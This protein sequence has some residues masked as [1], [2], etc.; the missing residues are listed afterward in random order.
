MIAWHRW[1]P[2][3]LCVRACYHTLSGNLQQ[4]WKSKWTVLSLVCFFLMSLSEFCNTTLIV[5][6]Y[7]HF[8]RCKNIPCTVLSLDRTDTAQVWRWVVDAGWNEEEEMMNK[9]VWQPSSFTFETWYYQK[10]SK[11]FTDS[12]TPWSCSYNVLH[13]YPDC[14]ENEINFSAY[15]QDKPFPDLRI[16]RAVGFFNYV[17][18]GGQMWKLG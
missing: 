16:Q 3:V 12:I 7:P 14:E 11:C 17:F 8:M 6:E 1:E 4:A 2:E 13:T 5:A 9:E 18:H 15:S 10:T